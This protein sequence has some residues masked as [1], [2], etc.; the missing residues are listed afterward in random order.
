MTNWSN[1]PGYG[2]AQWQQPGQWQQPTPYGAPP[3]FGNQPPHWTAGGYPPP[4]KRSRAPWVIGGV[5]AAVLVL[6]VGIVTVVA[7][8]S[9]GSGKA[10]SPGDAVKG[11]L[12]ALARGDAEA[13]LAYAVDTPADKTYLTDEVL[14]KQ[15]EHSPIEDIRILSDDG[16]GSLG[17]VHVA[18]NFGDKVSDVT[19]HLDRVDG[20][21]KLKTGAIKL[22]F[23]SLV[24]EEAGAKTLTFF[25]T[26]V[27]VSKPAYVF[28]GWLDVGN[29][30]PNIEQ[31]SRQFPLLLDQMSGYSSGTSVSF[32]YSLNDTGRTAVQN[33][34]T[35]ALEQCATS[36]SLK[37][38]NCP[39]AV[40]DSGLVDG[41]AK[42]TWSRNID[43]LSIADYLPSDLKVRL[44]GTTSYQ[45]SA[46]G[47]NGTRSGDVTAYISGEADVSQDPPV[48]TLRS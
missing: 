47:G 39:Q 19:V 34:L 27:D 14:T 32:Q 41:T 46:Q 9:G 33:A 12:E 40:R 45:V 16:I 15:I 23:S 18:V 2:G 4:P 5:V 20:G 3:Q 17:S 29:T 6:V 48:V 28:P 10:G 8:S 30:N 31:E 44:N 36:T 1:D 38:A 43:D 26:P 11:Y 42:W 22:T 21:W 24:T 37:P 25:G 7:V 35:S 13:A